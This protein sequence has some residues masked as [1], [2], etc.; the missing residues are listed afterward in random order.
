MIK[1]LCNKINLTTNHLR[2]LLLKIILAQRN[3]DCKTSPIQSL[4]PLFLWAIKFSC[5]RPFRFYTYTC[6]TWMFLGS[7][8]L[9][10]DL[11]EISRILFQM[12]S[13]WMTL[14]SSVVHFVLAS[15]RT[16]GELECCYHLHAQTSF[17]LESSL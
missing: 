1:T 9:R 7:T 11:L 13:R 10:F 5:S 16:D 17:R 12:M 2:Y 6:F 3:I 8:I 4:I 14:R 15:N